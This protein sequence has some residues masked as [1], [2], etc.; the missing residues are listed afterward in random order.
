MVGNYL[1]GNGP[2]FERREGG[3]GMQRRKLKEEGG[4][5]HG[6]ERCCGGG[7]GVCEDVESEGNSW[8]K[9]GYEKG[10]DPAAPH[11]PHCRQINL[12][13]PRL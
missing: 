3:N 7:G 1:K 6:R 12:F 5:I 2:G 8:R 11:P 13:K 10:S 9:K 4:E